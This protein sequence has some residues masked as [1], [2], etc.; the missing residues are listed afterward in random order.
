MPPTIQK[1][2]WP[3]DSA[4]LLVH[5]VGSYRAPDYATV[6]AALRAAVGEARWASLAV[7][8][9]LYDEVNDWF[10]EKLAAANLVQSLLGALH[11]RFADTQLGAAA[12]EGAGDVVWPI[13]SRNA[14]GAL[15]ELL[16]AQLR[17]IVLDGDA[18]VPVRR[19][20]KLYIVSH[21]LG[22][23]HTYEALWAAASDPV[24]ALQPVT[25]G[26][27]FQA[28]IMM[29]SPVQLIRS[30]AGDIRSLVPAPGELA[31]LRTGLALPGQPKGA[32]GFQPSAR[33][34]ISLTGDLDPVGGYLFR[35]KLGWAFMDLDGQETELDHQQLAGVD[36]E[37]AL[38]GALSAARGAPLGL[39]L[40][41][42]NPHDWAGYVSR[43]AGKVAEWLA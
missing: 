37:A 31:S 34:L 7:Y 43:N 10:A 13:L 14:R 20:Q 23:F 4:L 2:V 27:R 24:Q 6:L 40:T 35:K 32:R 11:T 33:R 36:S 29:A 17:Q 25:D 8:T 19:M 9:A 26:V 39:S 38:A 16:L 30:V 12:A 3:G 5:G 1:Q 22:C 21:S 28:V 41:P 42:N 15:R 18:A